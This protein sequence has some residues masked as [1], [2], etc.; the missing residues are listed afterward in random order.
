MSYFL[1]NKKYITV[2]Q[3]ILFV[4]FFFKLKKII[5]FD[6]SNYLPP[7]WIMGFLVFSNNKK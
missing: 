4:L 1:K 6:L 7:K 2:S 3:I 5:K